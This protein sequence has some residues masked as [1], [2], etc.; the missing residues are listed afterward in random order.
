MKTI[1]LIKRRPVLRSLVVALLSI[2]AG[3]IIHGVCRAEVP[4]PAAPPVSEGPPQVVEPRDPAASLEEA[5][6]KAEEALA[7]PPSMQPDQPESARKPGTIPQI[8]VLDLAFRGGVL[9]IPI[10]LM[11]ILTVIFGLE[12]ALGLRR[13]KVVPASLIRGLGQLVEEKRGFDPR[14][15]YRLAQHYP[16]SAAN[17]LKAM[18]VKVGR[19]LPEIEQAM[20]E[21]TERE[22]DRLYSNVRFLTLSAAV[23]PA[24][25]TAGD[26]AGNDPGVLCD[27]A[28]SH[29]GRS[30]RDAGPGNL[31]GFGDDIRWPLCGHSRLGAGALFRGTYPKALA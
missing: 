27:V 28:S 9:M 2:G 1:P 7:A 10:T 6:R 3:T 11:S 17:V 12:R 21:A 26:S 16:S 15:A 30:S 8:N 29:R 23:T 20:K 24:F 31:H 4:A 25:G 13:R 22:A 14:A 19:P 18:L 5:D